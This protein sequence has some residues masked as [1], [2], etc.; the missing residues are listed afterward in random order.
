MISL[1]P[2]Q[3]AA[4]DAIYRY[5][6][7]YSGNCLITIPTAGGKSLVMATFVEGVL[8]AG[9]RQINRQS[10]PLKTGSVN[11]QTLLG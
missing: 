6:E 8:K 5:Y 11:A 4:I 1:R 10:S 3:S 2:Y 9:P 7:E